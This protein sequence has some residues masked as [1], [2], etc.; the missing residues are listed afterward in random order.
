MSESEEKSIQDVEK[1]ELKEGEIDLSG[2][3]RVSKLILKE[4]EGDETPQGLYFELF[5]LKT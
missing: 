2:D 4:G 3:G 1:I 5:V